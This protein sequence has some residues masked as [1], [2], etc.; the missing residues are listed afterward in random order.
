MSYYNYKMAE[1]SHSCNTCEDL[2]KRQKKF[3]LEKEY[4]DIDI[5]EIEE[6]LNAKDCDV[7]IKDMVKINHLKWSLKT[8]FLNKQLASVKRRVK[9]LRKIIDKECVGKTHVCECYS[10]GI[11]NGELYERNPELV[12]YEMTLSCP[13]DESEYIEKD[14]WLQFHHIDEDEIS[15]RESATPPYEIADPLPHCPE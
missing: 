11:N 1:Q 2:V 13:C 12:G 6:K 7:E 5:V 9:I 3:K 10:C 15:E 8:E 14:E 4:F